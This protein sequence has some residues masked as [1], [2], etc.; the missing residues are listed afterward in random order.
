MQAR[1]IKS[2]GGGA[3][4]VGGEKLT[5]V[6]VLLLL[7]QLLKCGPLGLCGDVHYKGLSGIS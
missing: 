5:Q 1:S 7:E 4:R 6:E 2:Q 3:G